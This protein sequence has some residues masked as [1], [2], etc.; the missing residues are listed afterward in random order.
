MKLTR[1]AFS[2]FKQEVKRSAIRMF[3]DANPSD[4]ML[5]TAMQNMG[6]EVEPEMEMQM[7]AAK[8]AV[9]SINAEIDALVAEFEKAK[10]MPDVA[11]GDVK[12]IDSVLEQLKNLKEELAVKF[13]D[14]EAAKEKFIKAEVAPM[15]EPVATV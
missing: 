4:E 13:A 2:D 3:A 15:A 10:A 7:E 6:I 5:D 11:E 12:E 9:D 14:V 1:Q 8:S